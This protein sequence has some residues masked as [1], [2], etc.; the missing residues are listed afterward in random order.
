M[1]M[2]WVGF[3]YNQINK[4]WSGSGIEEYSYA[5]L[6]SSVLSSTTEKPVM[7]AIGDVH[8]SFA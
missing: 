1:G 6:L 7:H 2:D 8:L 3:T 4:N 5:L